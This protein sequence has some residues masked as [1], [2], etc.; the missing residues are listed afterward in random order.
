[1]KNLNKIAGIGLIIGGF[2]QMVRMMPIALSDGIKMLENFPPHNLEDTLF[3]AQLFGWHISHIMVFLA[4][5]LLIT[6]F[7]GL[8]KL[9]T[10]KTEYRISILAFIGLSMGLILYNIGAVIDGLLLAELSDRVIESSGIEKERL[11]ILKDLK[12][13]VLLV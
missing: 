3:A 11:G 10:E 4:T 7:Y 5:P 12:Y 6:G 13:L 8:H 2:L 1:M 9:A